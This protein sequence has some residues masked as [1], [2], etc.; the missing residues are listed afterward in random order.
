MAI[1]GSS[2]IGLEAAASFRAR[3]LEVA[4]VSP[5]S[6]P[7]EKVFGRDVGLFFQ[8]LHEREGVTFHLG[9]T[10]GGFDDGTLR[11]DDGHEVAADFVLAGIGVRPR[12]A[13]AAAAGLTVSS[14]IEVD[15]FLETGLAGIYAAGDVASYPDPLS[16]QRL[17]IE[18]WV[19]AERQG[20]VAAANMLGA[21]RRF[22][23]VPFFWTEQY[24]TALR[25]VG[26]AAG[27]DEVRIE[28]SI[29]GGAF[30]AR[31]Y[32]GGA[33]R[34]SAAVGMDQASLEDELRLEQAIAAVESNP[35]K[36]AGTVAAVRHPS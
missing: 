14:G 12:T 32:E 10:A 7:F 13:L 17:R 29:E 19:V 2:F 36:S 22:G 3:G 27:W 1:L 31:Y 25:Y 24:G 35:V 33:L 4:I 16:G 15:E 23:A 21:R 34:A 20:Q 9:R 30:I 26:H 11:L 18:H 28:G 6:V 8:A 5:D